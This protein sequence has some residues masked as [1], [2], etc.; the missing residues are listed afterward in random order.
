MR[1]FFNE[2]GGPGLLVT[3]VSFG[4]KYGLPM[5]ADLVFDVRFLPNPFYVDSLKKLGGDSPE[6]YDYVTKGR[7]TQ[8]FMRL[9]YSMMQFLLPQ[10]VLEGKSQ[11]RIGIGC[12]GGQHRS[13]A[14]ASELSMWMKNEKY[15]VILEHRDLE[16]AMAEVSTR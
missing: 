10:F 4:Y 6:V 9:L 14:V 3:I 13:V 1:E 11:V 2:G 8:Q 5:D 12:T 15:K 16:K 7:T